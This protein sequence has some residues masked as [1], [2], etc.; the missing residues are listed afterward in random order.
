MKPTKA[1][2]F[3]L[4]IK[5]PPGFDMHMFDRPLLEGQFELGVNSCMFKLRDNPFIGTLSLECKK[6][7]ATRRFLPLLSEFSKDHVP[8]SVVGEFLAPSLYGVTTIKITDPLFK[9]KYSQAFIDNAICYLQMEQQNDAESE[10]TKSASCR[11]MKNFDEIEKF[12]RVCENVLDP[13]LAE[14][15]QKEFIYIRTANANTDNINHAKTA[16]QYLANINWSRRAILVPN[17][18]TVRRI[19][20]DEFYGLEEV[21]TRFEEICAQIRRTGEL[22]QWGILLNG[23]AGTGKTAIAKAFAKILDMPVIKIDVSSLSSAA[24]SLAGTSRVFNNGRPGRIIEASSISRTISEVLLINEIDKASITIGKDG[25]AS[26]SDVL[27]SLLDNQGFYDNYLETAFPTDTLFA[28]A[29]CNNLEKVSAPLKDRFLVINIPDYSSEEKMEIW[30]RYVFPKVLKRSNITRNQLDLTQNAKEELIT[31]YATEPGVRD[32]EQYAERLA[33]AYAREAEGHDASFI[34]IY[35]VADI[36]R[37]LGVRKRLSRLVA[38]TCG[39]VS[40]ICYDNGIGRDY[41]LEASVAPG[42]GD[43]KIFGG[44]SECQKEYVK[45]AVELAK[46]TTGIDFEDK[47]ITVFSTQP[48]PLGAKNYLGCATYAAVCSAV[49]RTRFAVG[50]IAFIGGV[51]LHGNLYFDD[52]DVLPLLKAATRHHI[53]TLYCPVGVSE[54]LADLTYCKNLPDVTIIEA[55]N[56]ESLISMAAQN[57]K[58]S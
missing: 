43:I 20:D 56:A 13:W 53:T 2:L 5:S 19:L 46:K 1:F 9:L 34:R 47:D 35:D 24:D 52:N 39:E 30:D 12:Y 36:R 22:P 44:I 57:S 33:G 32:L 37:L 6:D 17:A 4:K 27:L 3:F 31:A 55:V 45:V 18:E 49:M 48:L 29:T 26:S 38:V 7:D 40:S 14:A 42:R 15:M 51:D 50:D 41:L 10:K 11:P 58:L 21:K 25:Q 54:K 23:P 28:I 8:V 16:L